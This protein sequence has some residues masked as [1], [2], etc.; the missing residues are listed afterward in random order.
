MRSRNPR[1]REVCGGVPGPTR[2]P[3]RPSSGKRSSPPRPRSTRGRRARRR[4]FS[5]GRKGGGVDHFR[6]DVRQEGDPTQRHNRTARCVSTHIR[7]G[8]L[9]R[10]PSF[11]RH[12]YDCSA[13]HNRAMG[14]VSVDAFILGTHPLK[15]RDRIV[16]LLTRDSGKRRGVAKRARRSKRVH[17]DSRAN[18]RSPGRILRA[19]G[20]RAGVD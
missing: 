5:S 14:L 10:F 12:S 17:G 13:H 20:T 7:F 3:S 18:D 9:T 11:I 16:S 19:G 6:G 2:F 1:R 15:E 4:A 8:K